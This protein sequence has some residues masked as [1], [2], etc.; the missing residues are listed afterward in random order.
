MELLGSSPRASPY[1]VGPP[2]L[3]RARP[4]GSPVDP[5][6]GRTPRFMESAHKRAWYPSKFYPT[7]ILCL[8]LLLLLG[9][10]E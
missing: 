1:G 10:T 6:R 8:D 3:D 7:L 9:L 5:E 2:F 4:S